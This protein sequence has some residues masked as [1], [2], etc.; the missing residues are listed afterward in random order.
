MAPPIDIDDRDG[1]KGPMLCSL[2]VDF[3][4]KGKFGIWENDFFLLFN[5][6]LPLIVVEVSSGHG[7]FASFFL[8][9][10]SSLSVLIRAM[11]VGPGLL[12]KEEWRRSKI[13]ECIYFVNTG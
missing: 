7:I 5:P 12:S 1:I 10:I 9:E 4:V 13:E 3:K 2:H 11:E 8:P 6:F